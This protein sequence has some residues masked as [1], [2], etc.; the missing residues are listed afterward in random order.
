[1]IQALLP[2]VW[3]D[4]YCYGAPPPPNAPPADMPKGW[5]N[6][7]TGN[8]L[9]AA[10][11][12]IK[13]AWAHAPLTQRERR[14]L[15]LRYGFDLEYADIGFHESLSKQG[16]QQATERAVGRLVFWLNGSDPYEEL[17]YEA[18]YDEWVGLG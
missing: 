11:A 1:M 2:A 10:L 15:L 9:Y 13:A 12:D 18:T 14:C 16:A 6:K 4:S 17:D 8:T 7:A 3:D 5:S